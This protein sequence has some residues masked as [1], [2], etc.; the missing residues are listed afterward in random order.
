MI[1]IKC[2]FNNCAPIHTRLPSVPRV[3]EI[4]IF[5]GETYRVE[6]VVYDVLQG[7]IEIT[8]TENW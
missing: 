8:C 7:S 1:E 6:N 4:L 3:G 5:K 2:R